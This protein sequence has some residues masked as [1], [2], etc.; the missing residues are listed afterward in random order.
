MKTCTT[1]LHSTWLNLIY[2]FRAPWSIHWRF[3]V[4][5]VFFLI[6][7]T[8]WYR[9]KSLI[10]NKTKKGRKGEEEYCKNKN[11]CIIKWS[12]ATSD[13]MAGP[14][15]DRTT[16]FHWRPS[17]WDLCSEFNSISISYRVAI[18]SSFVCI[19][20]PS[21]SPCPPLPRPAPARMYEMFMSSKTESGEGSTQTVMKF[22]IAALDCDRA[23]VK[24]QPETGHQK[25]R[26]VLP[27]SLKIFASF[28]QSRLV[29]SLFLRPTYL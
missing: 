16:H 18:S 5:V 12:L 22:S 2:L 9:C 19:D 15:Y 24:T 1:R 28:S 11:K 23:P 6:A 8:N 13:W 3:V 27:R 26:Q 29:S 10:K 14:R 7:A 25:D 20:F 4:V 17:T 21:P